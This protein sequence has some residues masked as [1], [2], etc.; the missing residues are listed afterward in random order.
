MSVIT[1]I[2]QIIKNGIFSLFW[3]F[4]DPLEAE[5][6]Y[7]QLTD[8]M[9]RNLDP[10]HPNRLLA[11]DNFDVSVNNT[12]FIK[13]A[14]AIKKLES[15]L[16]DRLQRYVA[17][18]DYELPQSRIKLQI[19]SSAT[20]SKHKV[21]IR[22]RFSAEGEQHQPVDSVHKG[23]HLKVI[24][25]QGKGQT[26]PITPGK[27]YTIGR[28]STA[29]ICL[30][31][32]NISKKQA[33]LYFIQDDKITIVDEGSANGTFINDAEEAIKGSLE[34]KLGDKIKFCKTN[35]VVMTLSDK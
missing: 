8:Q 20:I 12:V 21:E 6:L 10:N 11:P 5:R 33:T 22:A 9:D 14:H 24:E 7:G 25:G 19:I 26:W 16:Q 32:D 29:E 13:H 1:R 27:T 28:V 2:D 4:M 23:L 3:W 31:F 30:P 15:S 18:K 35:P 34:L 17:D